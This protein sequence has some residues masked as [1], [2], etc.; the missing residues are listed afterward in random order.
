MHWVKE[1]QYKELKAAEVIFVDVGSS[2]WLMDK[3]M[4]QNMICH[5]IFAELYMVYIFISIFSLRS[6]Q[7]S[8]PRWRQRQTLGTLMRS[9]RRRPSRSRLQTSVSATCVRLLFV[10]CP[11]DWP[12]C[13]LCRAQSGLWGPQTTS[14]LPSVLLLRQHQRVM[15]GTSHAHTLTR[16]P[17]VSC[18]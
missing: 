1:M 17:C 16:A 10:L 5:V 6:P 12:L 13:D 3:N 4:W 15:S 11:A 2:L 9:S 18:L 14:T 8:S 7:F